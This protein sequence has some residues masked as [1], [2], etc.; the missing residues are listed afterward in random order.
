MKK[1]VINLEVSTLFI[2]DIKSCLYYKENKNGAVA[3]RSFEK[4]KDKILIKI[5]EHSFITL[6][7]YLRGKDKI[8][9]DYP[10][11]GKDYVVPK[12]E[13]SEE[14]IISYSLKKKASLL[15]CTPKN[16]QFNKRSL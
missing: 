1:K 11:K 6:E 5:E 8:L 12:E 9:F 10:T 2:G 15:N 13:I 14:D 4:A 3:L 7:N 16:G